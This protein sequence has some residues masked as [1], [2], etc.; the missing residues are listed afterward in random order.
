MKKE[1][2]KVLCLKQ[3]SEVFYYNSRSAFD[4]MC[5]KFSFLKLTQ[6]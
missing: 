1:L 4:K 5:L 3:N 2:K 6:S